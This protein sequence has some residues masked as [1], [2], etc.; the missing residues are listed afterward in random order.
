MPTLR[1]VTRLYLKNILVPTDFSAA[2]RVALPFATRL[3]QIYGSTILLAHSIPP[4]PHRQVVMDPLPAQDDVVWQHARRA[5]GE[6]GLDP[7]L[8]KLPSKMILDRGDLESVIPALVGEHNVDLIVLGTHG[9]RGLKKVV[10]GSSAE[11]IYR[12]ASCPVLTV[13]PGVHPAKEWKLRRI[14]CPLDIAEDPEPVLQYGLSIAEENDAEFIV[15]EAVPLVPWQH[16]DSVAQRARHTLEGLIPEEAREWCTP[17]CVVRWET[18]AEAILNEAREQEVDL[19]VMSVHRSRAAA[20]SAHLPWPV[21]SE[22]VSRAPCPVL[23][24]R[25]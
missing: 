12:C 17:K 23:T 20:W 16:R 9:R 25:V 15:L 7:A 8:V 13:G 6:F 2:S 19:I 11:K 22:V 24:L 10:L 5:I 1:R 4:E 18:P 21:A 3:A 14:L